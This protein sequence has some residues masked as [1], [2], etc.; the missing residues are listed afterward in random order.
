LGG[1][2]KTDDLA[3]CSTANPKFQPLRRYRIREMT[4]HGFTM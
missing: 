3:L 2:G 4:L 1:S